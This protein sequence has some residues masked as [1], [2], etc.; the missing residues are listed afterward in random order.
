VTPPLVEESAEYEMVKSG[1]NETILAPVEDVS[2]V[3]GA[4]PSLVTLQKSFELKELTPVE[5]TLRVKI[6]DQISGLIV[7]RSSVFSIL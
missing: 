6:T 2:Q 7:T 5:Y 1:G 4:A 3:P